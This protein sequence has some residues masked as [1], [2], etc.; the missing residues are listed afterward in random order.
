MKG[1]GEAEGVVG[2]EFD[3][4]TLVEPSSTYDGRLW[5]GVVQ[6]IGGDGSE[7]GRRRSKCVRTGVAG[8]CGRDPR[9]VARRGGP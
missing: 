2:P 8:P 3:P 9:E 5:G 7:V 6:V 1:V 4:P